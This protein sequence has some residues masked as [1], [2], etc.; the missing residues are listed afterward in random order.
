MHV[1]WIS[2]SPDTPSG[3]GNVSRFVCGGLARRGYRV[4]ILGWQ[5]L[6]RAQWN[7][8]EVYPV[9]RDPLG[10]DVVYPLMT[11][12][13]PDVVAT[14]SD[15][16]W[17]PYFSA[18]HVRRQMELTDTPWLLYFPIDG[19]TD[20]ERLPPSWVE[21]LQ[22]VDVPVA[23]SHYG[24]RIVTQCGVACD[25]IPHGVDLEVFSPPPDR[26]AAKALVGA[27]GRFVVLAD[28]RNQPRKMLPRLLDAFARFA[29]DKPDALLHLHTDPDDDFASSAIYS[30]DVRGDVRHLGLERS[31][32]FSDKFSVLPGRGLTL[33]RLASYY[34][35]ADVFLLASTGEGF[36]LPTLQASAAGVVPLGGGYSA[37]RELV[38]GHGEAIDIAAWTANE[39]GIRGALIDV[40]DA[41]AKLTRLY[42]DRALLGRRS[43]QSRAFAEAYGWD[44]IVDQWDALLRSIG[45]RRR[46]ITRSAPKRSISGS[47]LMAGSKPILDGVSVRVNVV[48]RRYGHLESSILAERRGRSSD[49]KI[50]T[51]P[52]A[53]VVGTVK[54][55]RWF[56]YVGTGP[57]DGVPFAR[58]EAIFPALTRWVAGAAVVEEMRLD[59]AQSVLLLDVE[60]DMPEEMLVD[61]ALLG[62]PYVGTAKHKGP[63]ALWPELEPRDADQAVA[64]ARLILTDAALA[65]RM[66]NE[67]RAACAAAY[68]A[69]ETAMAGS[70]RRL[71][72]ERQSAAAQLEER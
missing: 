10:M 54:V 69:D 8:C 38:E 55:I 23:M 40:A 41:A 29:H 51:V 6:A 61:A 53:A 49:V 58:L 9:L 31:V 2:D 21:L 13:R 32:R 5:S 17:L 18:P 70:L 3:F 44:G 1:M 19:D 16:W 34:R 12:L 56:G 68:G 59:I 30:Y 37:T 20:G 7:G 67:A 14:L 63:R 64:M 48:E 43:A 11:R 57:G 36:G 35:A 60:G 45:R 66:V 26:D 22:E 71:F 42:D 28:C 47:S 33:E 52:K 4:S 46:R 62:V 65:Q 27:E 24:K 39:F 15:V 25:Y 50:P 72:A